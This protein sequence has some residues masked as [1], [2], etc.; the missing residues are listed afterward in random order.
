MKKEVD[1]TGASRLVN[2]GMIILVTA[3]D[4]KRS[5]ITPCAWHMPVSKD[6][7]ILGVALA[8]KHFSSE[9]IKKNREF[10]I[11]IPSYNLLEKI[12]FCGKRSG[13]ETDKF[14]EANLTT[15]R[16][17]ILAKAPKIRECIA[18]IECSLNCIEEVGDHFIFLGDVI[19]AQ[20]DQESF[21]RGFWDTTKV[22]LPFHL[23]AKYFFK[24][25]A[26]S[27]YQR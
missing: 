1:K 16:S 20:A 6:P 7:P 3:G 26:Y 21:S 18:D 17:N 24:S 11:N 12:M 22:D 13:R 15:E 10:V 8:K 27:E 14:K 4:G 19:Y 5:T 9:L 23:G 2:C 25:S